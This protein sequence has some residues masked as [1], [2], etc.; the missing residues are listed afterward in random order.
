MLSDIGKE[1]K[2]FADILSGENAL[3]QSLEPVI[4]A[5]GGLAVFVATFSLVIGGFR[6]IT[7]SG[8]PHRLEDAKRIIRNALIGLVV[9]LAAGVLV[10][11]LIS[12]YKPSSQLTIDSGPPSISIEQ[13]DTSP[14]LVDVLIKAIS[15]LFQH[16]VQSAAKP[17]LQG[18]DYFTNGTPLMAANESVFKLWAAM[19]GIAN[20]ILVIV[21]VLLGFH[22]M[23]FS[24]LGL[25]E[26]DIK[27][28]LPQLAATF[29]VMNISIFVI[30]IVVRISNALIDA[31]MVIFEPQDVWTTLIK[32]TDTAPELGLVTLII[33]VG[34]LILAVLLMIYYLMRL[35]TLYIGAVLAPLVVLLWLL[36]SFK[37]FVASAAKSYVITIFVLFVH[38]VVLLIAASVFGGMIVSSEKGPHPLM[39]A[40]IGC[41]ILTSLLKTQGLMSQLAYA[42]MGPKALRKLGSQFMTSV[43]YLTAHTKTGRSSE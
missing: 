43:S 15:G 11:V 24:A 28:M 19:L 33:M 22:I 4:M 5:L 9:V 31:V 40:L 16:L 23:S 26:V 18:L 36:P 1:M 38:V 13:S 6:Y 27:H 21:V 17:L 42:S 25:D 14:G 32:V 29:L 20:V 3:R 41:A 10:Q 39:S 35:V 30:D 7:S 37:D 8:R 12:T 34:F 2:V